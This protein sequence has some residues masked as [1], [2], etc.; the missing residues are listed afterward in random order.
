VVVL[1]GQKAFRFDL[2][3]V[4]SGATEGISPLFRITEDV[5]AARSVPVLDMRPK[6]PVPSG[7][8]AEGHAA[9]ASALAVLFKIGFLPIE[10]E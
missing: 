1:T 8:Y 5:A 2:R 7:K 10:K 9:A 6:W 4:G 3:R